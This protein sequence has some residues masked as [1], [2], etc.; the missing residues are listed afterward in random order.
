VVGEQDARV[1][2]AQALEEIALYG[3]VVIAASASERPLTTSELD[4]VL[5]V[6]DGQ[7]DAPDGTGA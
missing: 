6:L 5:G 1:T 3:E 7:G 4:R 2:D